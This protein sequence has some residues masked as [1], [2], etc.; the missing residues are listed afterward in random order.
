MLCAICTLSCVP[1]P[2]TWSPPWNP[3]VEGHTL[4]NHM[5]Q[6]KEALGK[7]S[8]NSDSL[9]GGQLTVPVHSTF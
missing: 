1:S 5:K 9:R 4:H 6:H 2:D 3:F 8:L 7:L